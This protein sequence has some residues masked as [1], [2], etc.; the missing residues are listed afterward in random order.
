MVVYLPDGD[1][2]EASVSPYV[3][4]AVPV[5]GTAYKGTMPGEVEGL[6]VI[7]LPLR[8]VV[9]GYDSLECRELSRLDPLKFLHVDDKSCGE[10]PRLVLV[11]GGYDTVKEIFLPLGRQQAAYPAAFS[12][13]LP[14][15]EYD[16][17]LVHFVIIQGTVHEAYQPPEEPFAPQLPVFGDD[18]VCQFSYIVLPV[19]FGKLAEIVAVGIEFL[20][21]VGVHHGPQKVLE[22]GYARHLHVHEQGVVVLSPHGKVSFCRGLCGV[23]GH[24][25]QPVH[26]DVPAYA[27]MGVEEV[28]HLPDDGFLFLF[29]RGGFRG[30]V[31]IDVS[32]T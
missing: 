4:Q 8:D 11:G 15:V 12:L 1:S 19:P 30:P 16:D 5:V 13:S 27:V 2:E 29:Q 23:E 14:A 10:E 7:Y 32:V 6:H 25:L 22:A 24:V 31:G 17:E 9:L 3:L 20:G 28:H 18:G 21:V 26:D